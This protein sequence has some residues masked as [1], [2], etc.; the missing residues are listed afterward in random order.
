[1]LGKHLVLELELKVVSANQIARFFDG[2]DLTLI[3]F[4]S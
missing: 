3:S 1:M 2:I 4:F